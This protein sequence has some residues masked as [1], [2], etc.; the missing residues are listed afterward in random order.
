MNALPFKE[1][2]FDYIILIDVIHHECEDLQP[3]LN[4]LY[5]ILKP[6]G[7]LLLADV[8]AWGL[9]QWH[10]SLLLPKPIYRLLRATYHNLI[11]STHQ[12]ADYEFPTSPQQ[13]QQVLNNIGF[14]QITFYPQPIFYPEVAPILQKI[15]AWL[16]QWQRISIYHN[17]HYFLSA[18]K[19]ID[20]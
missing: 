13:V 1:S 3:I 2:V 8:N 14:Q 6:N 18:K 19:T 4:S 11:R 12:P 5:R 17:Y 15:Y 16:S 20:L 9:F 7:S 10:K